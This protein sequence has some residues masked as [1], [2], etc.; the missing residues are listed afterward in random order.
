MRYSGTSQDQQLNFL[1]MAGEKFKS[2]ANGG[3]NEFQQYKDYLSNQNNKGLIFVLD[4]HANNPVECLRQDQ[5]LQEVLA[6]IEQFGILKKTDAVY[7]VVTKADLFPTE[8]KQRFADD[9]IDNNYR[10]FLNACK[11]AKRKYKFELK[12]FPFSIGPTR[13]GY[14]LEDCN[15]ATNKNLEIYPRKLVTQIEQDFAYRKKGFFGN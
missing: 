2:V 5:N 13:F 4:Y 1:D 6:L 10:N 15:S 8:N 14:I 11:E 3:M 12:S 7:L 9:Y